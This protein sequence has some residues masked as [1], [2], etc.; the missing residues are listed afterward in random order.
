LGIFLR[1]NVSVFLLA[2]GLSWGNLRATSGQ[3]NALLCPILVQ[4]VS[5]FGYMRGYDCRRGYFHKLL[6]IFV[7]KLLVDSDQIQDRETWSD[8]I[9]SSP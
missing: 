2:G 4:T 9:F 5:S 7:E 6:N 1:E 8:A 3:V